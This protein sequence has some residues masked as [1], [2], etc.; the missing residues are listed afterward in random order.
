MEAETVEHVST[1]AVPLTPP[2]MA[3]AETVRMKAAAMGTTWATQSK[4]QVAWGA[5]GAAR[6]ARKAA[7]AG[8]W[9]RGGGGRGGGACLEED[10]ESCEDN[11]AQ[12]AQVL[13]LSDQ[14]RHQLRAGR[15]AS[16]QAA[17]PAE[18]ASGKFD[19]KFSHLDGRARS[20]VS[21]SQVQQHSGASDLH[22]FGDDGGGCERPTNR[23]TTRCISICLRRSRCLA[24]EHS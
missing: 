21:L 2:K 12:A 3:P 9:W 4:Q 14:H 18:H 6:A 5:G 24:Q 23:D 20:R 8:R 13:D 7:G 22:A 1:I 11:V 16:G 17:A 15:C 10:H 19:L